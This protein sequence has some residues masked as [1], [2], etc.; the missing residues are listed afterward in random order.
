[1]YFILSVSRSQFLF[2]WGDT[3]PSN[4]FRFTHVTQ[5]KYATRRALNLKCTLKT[6]AYRVLINKGRYA[7][8]SSIFVSH[9]MKRNNCSLVQ[10]LTPSTK[11]S[12]QCSSEVWHSC[13]VQDWIHKRVGIIKN[14]P[15]VI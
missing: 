14:Y 10:L 6:A 13:C 7:H 15:N 1:M 3:I 12:N 2:L 4:A 8:N 5:L 9:V 11:E